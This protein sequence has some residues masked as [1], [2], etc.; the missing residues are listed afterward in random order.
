MEKSGEALTHLWA[1]LSKMKFLNP[2]T[3]TGRAG[4]RFSIPDL[5]RFLGNLSLLAPI[6]FPA[7]QSAE[8]AQLQT[9]QKG[10]L[11]PS[12]ATAA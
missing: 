5:L 10:K 8:N 11:F 12:E 1:L 9:F 2:K 7:P 6:F 4:M 3:R